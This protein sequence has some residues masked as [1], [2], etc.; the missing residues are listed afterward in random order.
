M[1]TKPK[2]HKRLRQRTGTTILGSD[3]SSSEPTCS[4]T[5]R[6]EGSFPEIISN[7]QDAQDFAAALFSLCI[8]LLF[9]SAFCDQ[10]RHDR[11]PTLQEEELST[12]FPFPDDDFLVVVMPFSQSQTQSFPVKR[13]MKE[14]WMKERLS[15]Q[16]NRIDTYR[17]LTVSL[18]RRGTLSK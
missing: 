2:M 15:E 10:L 18:F 12:D 5:L 13:K 7:P 16:K 6:Q 1:M 4:A 11:F 9:T 3:P 14:G 17:S 8:L